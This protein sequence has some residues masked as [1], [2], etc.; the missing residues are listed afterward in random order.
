VVQR[1]ARTESR[2][3]RL[4]GEID[5]NP[6]GIIMSLAHPMCVSGGGKDA[7]GGLDAADAGV[8]SAG[9]G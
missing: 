1:S 3:P 9:G 6:S 7:A 2:F 5:C 4:A 8:D